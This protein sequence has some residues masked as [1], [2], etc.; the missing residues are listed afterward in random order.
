[1]IVAPFL[2]LG[3]IYAFKKPRLKALEPSLFPAVP[4]DEF[5]RWKKLE[6]RSINILL[7]GTWGWY[8]IDGPIC[9]ITASLPSATSEV[10]LQ[11]IYPILF[12]IMILISGISGSKAAKLKNT[13]GIVLSK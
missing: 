2:V 6:L 5:L 9:F 7:W 11:I 1:M 10:I 4:R 8:L 12:P 13:L 3:V